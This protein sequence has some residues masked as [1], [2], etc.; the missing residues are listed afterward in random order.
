M[1]TVHRESSGTSAR[2]DLRLGAG[3]C[4]IPEGKRL[5]WVVAYVVHATTVYAQSIVPLEDMQLVQLS[6]PNCTGPQA[7]AVRTQN[8]GY[9]IAH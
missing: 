7:E 2:G 4:G 6:I 5:F 8:L 1:H 9:I 3:T